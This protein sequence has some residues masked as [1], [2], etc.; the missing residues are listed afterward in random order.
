[1]SSN[2]YDVH[3]VDLEPVRGSELNKTRPA[4][5]VSMDALNHA[6]ETVV[7]CPLTS[8]LHPSWRTRLQVKVAGKESE[9]AADQ[10]R[11]VSRSRLGKKIGKL[12][13]A[14]AAALRQLLQEMYCQA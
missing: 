9:V 6:L 11:V 13:G 4:V 8:K 10:I 14:D 2:R 5:I 7:V 3:W 12:S 1:M